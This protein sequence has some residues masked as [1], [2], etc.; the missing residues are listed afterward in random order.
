MKSDKSCDEKWTLFKTN[1]ELK[2]QRVQG[3][4]RIFIPGNTQKKNFFENMAKLTK[5]FVFC[6]FISS[7]FN[8]VSSASSQPV[9]IG[10]NK[11]Q[12]IRKKSSGIFFGVIRNL[13]HAK[14]REKISAKSVLKMSKEIDLF[15]ML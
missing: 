9:S 2:A 7:G 13:F 1:R 3:F 11:S 14:S 10:F 8:L 15:S 5:I 4:H 6:I 12:E